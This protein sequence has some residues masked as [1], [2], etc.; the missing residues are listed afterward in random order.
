MKHRYSICGFVL[1][2]DTRFPEL[3]ETCNLT[4]DPARQITITLDAAS[5]E[6]PEPSEWFMR[7]D[8]PTGGPWSARAR[9]PAGYVLRFHEFADFLVARVGRDITCLQRHPG[10]S[11]LAIRALVL[12]HVIPPVIALRGRYVL[13]AAAVLTDAGVCVFAGD[14]G[15]GKSTIAA[16]LTAA[17]GHFLT[18]DCLVIDEQ[19]TAIVAWSS[20]PSIKLRDDAMQFLTVE[21]ASEPVAEYTTKRR[22]PASSLGAGF[23]LDPLPLARIYFLTRGDEDAAATAEPLIQRL[24]TSAAFMKLVKHSIRLDSGDRAMLEREFQFTRRIVDAVPAALLSLPNDLT[25]LRLVHDAI[26]ADA[27]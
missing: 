27:A 17:G 5:G 22:V 11:E 4:N 2:S 12:D 9:T 19:D 7:Q 24:P 20:H 25:K 16:Q 6:F 15:A 8:L 18:D 13:H 3:S 26:V 14:S 10:V 23:S 1:E 21:C